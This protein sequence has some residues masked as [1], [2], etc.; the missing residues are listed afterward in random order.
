[1]NAVL[2]PIPR[3]PAVHGK[4]D[5][6]PV[7]LIIVPVVFAESGRVFIEFRNIVSRV[8]VSFWSVI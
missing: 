4:P 5:Q 8:P 1:M 3:L 7:E 2:A 6:A